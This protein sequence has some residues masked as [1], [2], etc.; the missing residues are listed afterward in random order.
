MASSRCAN[1]AKG[2]VNERSDDPK[3]ERCPSTESDDSGELIGVDDMLAYFKRDSTHYS[4]STACR[5]EST[6]PFG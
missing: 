4:Y 5:I 1:E 2:S 6:L 3:D